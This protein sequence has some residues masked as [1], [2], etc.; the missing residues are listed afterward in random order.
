MRTTVYV[1]VHDIG[2]NGADVEP[3]G[4]ISE[5]AAD[6]ALAAAERSYGGATGYNGATVEPVDIEL[7]PGIDALLRRATTAPAALALKPDELLVLHVDDIAEDAVDKWR[8]EL[9]ATVGAGRWLLIS[10]TAILTADAAHLAP[11]LGL[12]TTE[13]LL[14]ELVA[15]HDR[16]LHPAATALAAHARAALSDLPAALLAYRTVDV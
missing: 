9:N 5:A 4:Y 3:V 12:A 14:E 6:A 15:R 7:E 10:G 11:L 16:E 8:T 13:E 2:L 1:I